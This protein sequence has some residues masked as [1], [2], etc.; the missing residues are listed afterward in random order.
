M[1][2]L[3]PAG[4][5]NMVAEPAPKRGTSAGSGGV[6]ALPNMISIR[7]PEPVSDDTLRTQ[8]IAA[9][10]ARAPKAARDRL[11]SEEQRTAKA[12]ATVEDAVRS[13]AKA[14]DKLIHARLDGRGIDKAMQDYD[15]ATGHV[16]SMRRSA[17]IADEVLEQLRTRILASVRADL[18]SAARAKL[19]AAH[20]RYDRVAEIMAGVP[21]FI[22]EM[23]AAARAEEAAAAELADAEGQLPRFT[24]AGKRGDRP[25]G[26]K[27]RTI[28]SV[29]EHLALI[30][31]EPNRDP[32]PA[33]A[34]HL[35]RGS[36]GSAPVEDRPQLRPLGQ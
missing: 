20:Q 4:V 28:P 29:I 32:V 1:T 31:S 9:K 21:A 13:E 14:R 18:E 24:L 35:A 25:T 15:R 26:A 10:L 2:A 22:A 17:A 19:A 16:A 5:P 11:R 34:Q 27:H 23:R 6:L 30:V 33:T 8:E 12:H 36:T 7:P 3:P